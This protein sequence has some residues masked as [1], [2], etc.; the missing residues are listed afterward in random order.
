MLKFSIFIHVAVAEPGGERNEHIT[1]PSISS[2][3]VVSPSSCSSCLHESVSSGHL[4]C[5]ARGKSS[6]KRRGSPGQLQL[7][8]KRMS[9]HTMK[10]VLPK[11]EVVPLQIP[12]AN[13]PI[14]P[15][16]KIN[17]CKLNAWSS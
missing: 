4:A 6:K 11:A 7:P 17:K 8:L 1:L 9:V 15:D 3:P 5:T 10:N 14:A 16:G 2:L 12:S 13:F